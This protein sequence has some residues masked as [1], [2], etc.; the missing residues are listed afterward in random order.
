MTNKDCFIFDID[1]TIANNEH[2][3]RFLTQKPKDW[4]MYNSLMHL[5]S[6]IDY[7]KELYN[8]LSSQYPVIICTG[9]QE[10][11]RNVTKAWLWGN[12]FEIPEHMFMRATGDY[13]DDCIVK[14]EMLDNIIK[15]GYNVI[16]VFDDRHKVV[17]MWRKRGIFVYDVNQTRSIF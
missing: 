11:N 15:I 12:D 5:D 14:E 8:I 10:D 2:R 1:G 17:N 13:R 3:Q 16:G 4:A 7:V 9:R 6:P